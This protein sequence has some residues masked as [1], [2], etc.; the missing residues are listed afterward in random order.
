[1]HPLM[2]FYGAGYAEGLAGLK[3][4]GGTSIVPVLAYMAEIGVA[5]AIIAALL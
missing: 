4:D 2:P 5:L 1:M 3:A